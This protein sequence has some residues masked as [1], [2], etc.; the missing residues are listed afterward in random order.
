MAAV[1]E[2]IDAKERVPDNEEYVIVAYESGN[3]G[4]DYYSHHVRKDWVFKHG[5][6]V[7]HWMPFP[8]HPKGGL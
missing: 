3:V 4:R 7:T 6:S 1:M 8:P 2:W 5:G